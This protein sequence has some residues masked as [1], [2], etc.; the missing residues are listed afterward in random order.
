MS[1]LYARIMGNSRLTKWLSFGD[2]LHM[3]DEWRY[4]ATI[5][6]AKQRLQADRQPQF[7][8]VRYF[9]AKRPPLLKG[10]S[11]FVRAHPW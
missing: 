9:Y 8:S 2:T 5:A 4:L 1:L 10:R 11:F 7:T 6:P 3:M